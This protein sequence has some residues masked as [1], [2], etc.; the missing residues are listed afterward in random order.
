MTKREQIEAKQIKPIEVGDYVL[1]Q[2]P[3]TRTENIS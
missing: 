3:Y 2:I 1:I